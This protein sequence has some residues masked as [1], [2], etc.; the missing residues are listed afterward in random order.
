MILVKNGEEKEKGVQKQEDEKLLQ[1]KEDTSDQLNK[2]CTEDGTVPSL[3][4]TKMS[5]QGEIRSVN[6][7]SES[8]VD[9]LLKLKFRTVRNYF[10][11]ER[12]LL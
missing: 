3:K 2:P 11:V 12:R 5:A 4:K 8:S 10:K 7:L 9:I 6:L 1:L